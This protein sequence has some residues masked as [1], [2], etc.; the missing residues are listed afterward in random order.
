MPR[1]PS[2]SGP[3]PDTPVELSLEDAHLVAEPMISNSL[4]DSALRHEMTR[5]KSRQKPG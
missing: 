4:S 2:V 5:P 3:V 1:G